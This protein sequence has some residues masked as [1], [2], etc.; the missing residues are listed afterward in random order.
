MSV[1]DRVLGIIAMTTQESESV[2]TSQLGE[3]ASDSSADL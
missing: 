2:I 3:L 1:T